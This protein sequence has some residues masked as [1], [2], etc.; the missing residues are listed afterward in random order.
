MVNRFKFFK[1]LDFFFFFSY[2]IF[3]TFTLS[4]CGKRYFKIMH[5]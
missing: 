4:I 5:P 1:N 2:T 3:F